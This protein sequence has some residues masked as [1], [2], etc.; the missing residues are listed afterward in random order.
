MVN[1]G[2][3][4]ELIGVYNRFVTLSVPFFFQP[5]E[6]V[7]GFSFIYFQFDLQS[8]DNFHLE[9]TTSKKDTYG[10]IKRM[11]YPAATTRKSASDGVSKKHPQ[12][13]IPDRVCLNCLTVFM[14]FVS[15]VL[16]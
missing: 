4:S 14:Q 11:Y 10:P 15:S 3:A 12:L 8:F 5:V 2:L 16:D 6:P 13:Y 1:I 7:Q 9:C